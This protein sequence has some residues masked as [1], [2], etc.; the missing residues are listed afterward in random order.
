MKLLYVTPL[1]SGFRDVLIDG[2]TEATG[3]PS[4]IRPLKRLIELG[5]RVDFVIAAPKV[6]LEISNEV[7]WLKESVFEF[8]RWRIGGL[9]RLLSPPRLYRAVAKRL[10]GGGYDFVYGHGTLGALACD[11]ARHRGVPCGQRLYGVK[12]FAQRVARHSKFRLALRHPLEYRS[13]VNRKCFLM[14]TKDGSRG[15]YVQRQLSP[16]PKY[17]F[18]HLL[19]GVDPFA[20]LPAAP[21][22]LPA[23]PKPFLSYVGRV[24]PF[25]Q[26]HLAI[27]LLHELRQAYGHDMRLYLAG[28]ISSTDYWN[29][30]Q[31]LIGEK[32]LDEHVCYLGTLS[33][34]QLL[35][36][37]RK[38]AA[39]LS[40]YEVTNLGN[41]VI[42]G[43]SAGGVV[44]SFK[45][46]SLDDIIE[47]QVDG[48]LVDSVAEAARQVNALLH[49][50][51][52][53]DSLRIAAK[54][55]AQMIFPSV[56]ERI[57]REIALI[58]SCLS[59]T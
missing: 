40:L 36:L 45:D 6:D 57:D 44:L 7:D 52:R 50:P 24:D 10:D 22:G 11:V 26:Q 12:Y 17:R 2:K 28:H 42:E 9:E 14:I 34:E 31:R 48:V 4:F 56:A 20:H 59:E 1:W 49:N 43:L 53:V 16:E 35:W 25:K 39:V 41:V 32:D 18:F 47:N 58:E 38:S 27:E 30:L 8:V 5:H 55:K 19:N 23:D 3:M 54:Q 51:A 21:P 37:Y 46:G 15:D 29:R 13:F 33:Q